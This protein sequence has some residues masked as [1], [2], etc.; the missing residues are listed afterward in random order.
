M[1]A[2][3]A[4]A[5]LVAQIAAFT[6]CSVVVSR[7]TREFISLIVQLILTGSQPHIGFAVYDL[8]YFACILTEKDH[9]TI[10]TLWIPGASSILHS[11]YEDMRLTRIYFVAGIRSISFRGGMVECIGPSTA[12]EQHH[13][14]ASTIS[15]R[16]DIFLSAL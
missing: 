8:D 5:F 15:G 2:W 9:F 6:I 1:E 11:A 10:A 12:T 14:I 4:A 3:T 7:M 16:N 13:T